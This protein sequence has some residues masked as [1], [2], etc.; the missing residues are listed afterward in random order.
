MSSEYAGNGRTKAKQGKA[1]GKILVVEDNP[2]QRQLIELYM[3][4]QHEIKVVQDGESALE[5]VRR[6]PYELILLD[7]GLPGIDGYEVCKEIKED[8]EL[9]DVSVI[10]L[11][12]NTEEEDRLRGFE[13]GGHDYLNK[14][15]ARTELLSKVAA[16]LKFKEE[17]R[18]LQQSVSYAS[19]TAMTAMSSA[20]EQG[21][22]LQFLMKSFTCETPAKLAQE[23]V[24]A[25]NEFGLGCLVQL[26]GNSGVLNYSSQGNCSPIEASILTHLSMSG[27]IFEFGTRTS[28]RYDHCTLIVLNM[29]RDDAERYGR[30]KDHLATLVEGADARMRSL[31]LGAALTSMAEEHL[32]VVNVIGEQLLHISQQSMNLQS[33]S[34]DTMRST[35][36]RLHEVIPLLDLNLNQEEMLLELL[37]AAESSLDDTSAKGE[38]VE[39]AMV[40]AMETLQQLGTGAL[41]EPATPGLSA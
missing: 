14:P 2:V 12:A 24:Q 10:F 30:L 29:P 33:F 34:L 38:V 17:R 26:R 1:M 21:T 40:T 9:G 20:A 7:I 36:Q 11:S 22:V 37:H 8:F 15:V 39:K 6:A 35:A 4:D 18:D 3:R 28:I 25:C 27:R 13:V 23:V 19:S 41:G 5:E 31:D 32:K 16:L